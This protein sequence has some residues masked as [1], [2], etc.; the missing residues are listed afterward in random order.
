MAVF[1]GQLMGLVGY[2]DVDRFVRVCGLERG[3]GMGTSLY[4]FSLLFPSEGSQKGR[5]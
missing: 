2:E 5:Q 1:G 4:T 3:R